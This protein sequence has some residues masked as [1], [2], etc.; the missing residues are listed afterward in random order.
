MAVVYLPAARGQAYANFEAT[1]LHPL[2]VTQV[3]KS[4]APRELGAFRSA[5]TTPKVRVWALRATGKGRNE[6]VYSDIR[7]GDVG[8]FYIEKRFRYFAPILFKWRSTTIQSIAGWPAPASGSYSLAIAL[9]DLVKC[10]LGEREYRALLSY[11]KIPM[12]AHVH[13]TEPS[14]QIMD[15]IAGGVDLE[16]PGDDI[17]F[18]GLGEE[19]TVLFK[20]QRVRERSEAIRLKVLETKGHACEVCEFDFQAQY[21][22]DFKKTA[23]VH[24]TNPLALG[25]R[26]AKSINDSR[27]S[28]ARATRP[29]TWVKTVF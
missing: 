15:A 21:G 7:I 24:H 9:G 16:A 27:F 4:I 13:S 6:K 18:S 1:V 19:G 26:R 28:A 2:P 14:Q 10:D 8:L 25:K 23:H 20:L 3:A 22:P 12:D 11:A 17:D 29:P 5:I